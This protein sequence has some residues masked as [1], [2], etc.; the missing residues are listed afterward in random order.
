MCR[1]DQRMLRIGLV[2]KCKQANLI[3][4]VSYSEFPD[5][6]SQLFKKPGVVC[7]PGQVNVVKKLSG[8]FGSSPAMNLLACS[9]NLTWKYSTGFIYSKIRYGF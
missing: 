2:P 5:L 8:C 1:K 7:L 9:K 4:A 3:V 6:V